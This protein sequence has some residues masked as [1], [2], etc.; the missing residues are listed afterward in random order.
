M[1]E[2]VLPIFNDAIIVES[3]KVLFCKITTKNII[4]NTT[5]CVIHQ[6]VHVQNAILYE[7]WQPNVRPKYNFVVY[8]NWQ[9]SYNR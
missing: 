1:R 9:K 6:N 5:F 3:H 2:T 7:N 4:Q 8:N